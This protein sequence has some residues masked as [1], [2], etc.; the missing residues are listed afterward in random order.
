LPFAGVSSFLWP[1]RPGKLSGHTI[2]EHH[3]LTRIA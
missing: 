1:L 2:H 3:A